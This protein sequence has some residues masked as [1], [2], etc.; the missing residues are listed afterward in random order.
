MLSTPGLNV[1][2][3]AI[4]V[5]PPIA[6]MNQ[7]DAI[8]QV[9]ENDGIAHFLNSSLNKA[10]ISKVKNDNKWLNKITLRRSRIID[11]RKY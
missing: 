3:T 6:L 2:G 8:R 11:Q 10:E 4:V 5:S 1:E 7:V 9:S